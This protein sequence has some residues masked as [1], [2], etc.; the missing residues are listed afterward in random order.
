MRL[1]K[2]DLN[3]FIVFDALYRERSVT[4]VAL[5][6]NLTQPGVSNALSRLR[7]T[8]DDPLFIR[9]PDGMLPTPVADSIVADVRKG[10]ALLRRTVG[11]NAHFK[12][13]TAVKTFRLAMNDLT[14]SL[15]LSPMQA[16][17]K[18]Q[19]PNINLTSYYS[20]SRVA[21]EDLKSNAIDLL[22]DSQQV[23]AK[24]LVSMPLLELPYV[25]V[26]RANHPLATNPFTLKQYLSAEHLHVSSRRK[27]R[28]HVDIALHSIGHR[29]NIKMRVQNYLIAEKVTQESDLLWTAPN[30]PGTTGDLHIT[31]LPF[32]VEPLKLYLYW[33]KTTD[34]DPANQWMRELIH[35]V[36][37]SHVSSRP[38]SG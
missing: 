18:T 14:E 33:H 4:R 7:Q 17:L 24:E 6:L 19:A 10:L 37:P 8:F 13:L 16:M 31:P 27:G 1:D 15:L 12:P 35:S 28:G 26:M 21:T 34:D 2:I 5:S 30:L 11:S 3:L 9:S 36:V 22:I 25:V 38:G 23:N 29:R 20:D 32:E